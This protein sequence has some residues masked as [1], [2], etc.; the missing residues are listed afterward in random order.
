MAPPLSTTIIASTD[1]IKLPPVS[2]G[3]VAGTALASLDAKLA[4]IRR[5]PL[6]VG[7]ADETLTKLAS[8][9]YWQVHAAGQIVVDAGD[10][11][12]DVF[13][14][15]EG[16]VRV[17]MRTAFGYEAI[18]NDLGVGDFFG[19]LAAIDNAPR[20]ANVTALLQTRL[21][22]IPGDAFIDMALS[23]RDVGRRLLRLL[24]T[25]LRGKDERLIEFG[26]LSVRQRLI[27]E[28]LRLSRDRGGGER[29]ITPPPPQHV[30]AAR[31]GTRRETVSREMTEMSRSGSI[32][33]GRGAIVLHRPDTLRAEVDARRPGTEAQSIATRG[34]M[35]T[36]AP[37]NGARANGP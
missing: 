31:V 16:A 29:V 34:K 6:L 24:S 23:S 17:V 4:V 36:P 8:R 13:I 10:T 3:S 14:V 19:E 21:C 37:K 27:A 33:V 28:L 26:A 20:S 35:V 30:L 25:R 1:R 5:L 2:G 9:A 15:A 18:L 11:T 7:V 22:A 12:S 32:T